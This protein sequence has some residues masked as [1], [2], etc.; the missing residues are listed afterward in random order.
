MQ[1]LTRLEMA[2]T[3]SA[4]V[5][6]IN[7]NICILEFYG[8][9]PGSSSIRIRVHYISKMVNVERHQFHSKGRQ[10]YASTKFFVENL[11]LDNLCLK[12]FSI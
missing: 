12:H 5:N 7:W 11:I 8:P 6:R 3:N 10:K 9:E 1:S 2:L 4:I